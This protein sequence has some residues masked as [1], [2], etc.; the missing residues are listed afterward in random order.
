MRKRIIEFLSDKKQ[1]VILTAIASGLYPLLYYY[2]SNFS[3]INSWSQFMFFVTSYLLIPI[4]IFIIL[5]LVFKKLKILEKYRKYLLAVL[6]MCFFSFFILISTIGFKLK[7]LATVLLIS[8]FLGILMQKYLK[9]IIVFQLL[10]ASLVA[11]KLVPDFFR[12]FNYSTEWMIQKD[13][14]E[15]VKFIKKPNVYVIQPDGYAN[16]SE[17]KKEPY[18]FDNSEFENF[19]RTNDFKLYEGFRSNYFSTLSSNS[20][21]FAMKH[22]YFNNPKPKSTELYNARQIIVGNNPVVNIFKN[23][24]YKTFLMLQ[25]SYLLVNRAEIN[26]DYCNIKHSELSF[27][28]RGFGVIKNLNKDFENVIALNKE[29]NNFYFIEQIS[30]GHISTYENTSKGKNLERKKYLESIEEAN[31]FLKEIIGLINANDDNC[32]IVIVSD[33]G[34]FVGMNYTLE[35]KEKQIDENL[36]KSIF[37]TTL[38]IRWPNKTPPEYDEKLKTNVNLFR[39]LFT[40]LS[41]DKSYLNNL[42]D[43]K[44]YN[45][46]NSGAPYG[47]Y[48]LIDENGNIVFNRLSQ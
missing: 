28:A 5:N 44:S 33:H 34:G 11:I 36:I 31:L 46:I 4:L 9:K 18:N 30:P 15:S 24:G 37:T 17:L 38:A 40:Y 2:N 47:I 35:C 10:L 23:N 14:I 1:Y 7:L 22:H 32:I 12:H 25:K 3:L 42:E 39:V 13:S 21:M 16:F 41:D 45:V 29:T 6:N 48:E 27:M 20:S 19:L 43:D 8:F 26:F